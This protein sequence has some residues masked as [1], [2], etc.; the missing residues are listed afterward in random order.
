MNSYH[1]RNFQPFSTNRSFPR[2]E[3]GPLA[4]KFG[5]VNLGQG[6]PNWQPPQFVLDAANEALNGRVQAPSVPNLMNQYTRSGGHV[7]LCNTIATFYSPKFGRTI[8]PMTEVLL[9][10]YLL[11]T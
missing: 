1:S 4:A 10:H 7:S 9:L 8:N 2:P 5:A 11:L 6:F 3:Y